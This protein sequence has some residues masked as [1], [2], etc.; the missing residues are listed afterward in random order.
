MAK[1]LKWK[2]FIVSTVISNT[3]NNAKEGNAVFNT[4]DKL[5]LKSAE[6]MLALPKS[7]RVKAMTDYAI[8]NGG[9]QSD[10]GIRNQ[11]GDIATYYTLR[12]SSNNH[13]GC[14]DIIDVV[15]AKN[16]LNVETEYLCMAPSMQLDVKSV[17]EAKKLN[18][19]LFKIAEVKDKNGNILYHTLEFGEM[20]QTV[21]REN[22]NEIA[23]AFDSKKVVFTG[24]EYD[25]YIDK[26][27]IEKNK[28]FIYKGQ[29]YV[30]V[31]SRI[32]VVNDEYNNTYGYYS[33]KDDS[34]SAA[35]GDFEFVKVEPIKHIIENFD[36]LPKDLN[37]N[38]TGTAGTI[39]LTTEDLIKAPCFYPYEAERNNTLYQNSTIR[40]YLNGIN[41]NNIKEN[42]ISLYSA[43]AGGD[44]TGKGL[45]DNIYGEIPN[46]YFLSS[47][48][49][50]NDKC[51]E[52]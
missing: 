2:D 9:T 24:K 33:Y 43:T 37:P 42:G 18:D 12:S 23:K 36:E 13:S 4:Y 21:D 6:E 8:L 32:H 30:K 10:T 52:R 1:T 35:F 40:G 11:K 34:K 46:E 25:G 7:M 22:H 29:K 41:V 44:Y 27:T 38:G 51:M 17:V 14:M 16:Y 15:G 47:G 5:Y 19:N 49:E 20:P 50:N 48:K 39:S 26:N 31:K 45:I 28:E 3:D